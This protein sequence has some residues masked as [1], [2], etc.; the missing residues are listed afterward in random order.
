MDVHNT[1]FTFF[2]AQVAF[3]CLLKSFGIGKHDRVLLPGYTSSFIPLT[4]CHTAAVPEYTDIDPQNYTSLLSHY[5]EAYERTKSEGTASH[6]ASLLIHH[7]YGSPNPDTEDIVNWAKEKG[8]LVIEYCAYAPQ[9]CHNGRALGTSGDGAFFTFGAQGIAQVNNS[10]YINIMAA[11]KT[12]APPPTKTD[13]LALV[14]K[15]FSRQLLARS[16][17]CRLAS[18][19]LIK[20]SQFFDL[21]RWQEC[22][23]ASPRDF[24]KGCSRI[25][26]QASTYYA[27]RFDTITNHKIQLAAY[28]SELLRTRGLP[29]YNYAAGAILSYYPVRVKNKQDCL[30]TAKEVGLELGQGFDY[31]L[32]AD[33]E[34][35]LNWDESVLPNALSAA[36]EVICLPLHEQITLPYAEQLVKFLDCLAKGTTVEHT[37]RIPLQLGCRIPYVSALLERIGKAGSRTESPY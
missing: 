36:Q 26:C 18:K 25:Q 23:E 5:K 19:H 4:V 27:K 33:S 21:S 28:Y 31:P 11:M 34:D 9:I 37:T 29:V 16:R 17:Y 1:S 2:N 14:A 10:K 20:S 35:T 12:A 7:T 6:L 24:F 13:S 32:Y 3:Y 8:L 15:H 22:L 30:S